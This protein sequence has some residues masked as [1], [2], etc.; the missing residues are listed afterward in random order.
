MSL[1][2]AAS[3]PLVPNTNRRIDVSAL[4]YSSFLLVVTVWISAGLFGLYILAFYVDALYQDNMEQWNNVLP[5]LYSEGSATSTASMGLHFAFGGIVLILGSIQ[6]IK[7]LRKHFPAF[8]RWVG[9]IYVVSSLGAAIGGL[10]FIALKGTVGGLVMDIGFSLYGILTLVAAIETYR[11]AVAGRMD[12]HRAWAIRLY[13]LAI[14]SWLYRI[15]YGFWMLLTGGL[16]HENF[17][18]LFDKVMAFFFYIPNLLVA[19]LFIRPRTY[20]T[21]PVINGFCTVA[22]LL[23]TFFLLTGTY[24][25]IKFYWGRP[26]LDWMGL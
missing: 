13:A 15:D 6:L 23:I 1:I 19:E 11:H 26:I 25:F 3:Q 5:G 17:H 2:D 7:S 21:S 16:G 9:R 12:K 14:G 8:H 18:G 20:R 10:L 22:L 24:Y 4:R